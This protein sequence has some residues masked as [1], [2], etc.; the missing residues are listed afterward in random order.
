M[1]TPSYPQLH[2]KRGKEHAVSKGHPW[3]FAG[4]IHTDVPIEQYGAIFDIHVPDGNKFIARGYFNGHSQIAFRA[5]TRDQNEAID[6]R[7]FEKKFRELFELRKRFINTRST[8]AFRC[9][10]GESDGIPGLI[11]DKYNDVFVIQIHTMGMELLR[12]TIVEAMKE[13]YN[14]KTIYERSDVGVRKH[15]NLPDEP[16]GHVWGERLTGEVEILEHNVKFLVNVVDG[17][18][19]GFFLDQRDNRKALQSYCTGKRVLNCFSY[20]GGFSVYAA[21]AGATETISVDVAAAALETAK[22][23]FEINKL[24]TNKHQFIDMDVFNY[25]DQCEKKGEKFDVIILDPPAFVKNKASL[26]KG[27]AG[28]LYINERALHLLP[29][30][31]ILVS[32]SCSAHVSDEMLQQTLSMAAA[33]AHCTLKAVEIRHQPIDHPFNVQFIEGK[34]LKYYVMVKE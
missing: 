16:K 25:I 3:I 23:N 13:V 30:G 19:T 5:L 27:L 17:Q 12:K 6:Q 33:R 20:T 8:N 18:K 28:Y 14:P 22:R 9:V 34:Y 2:I 1:T 29:K 24:P 21:L 4:A 15:E 31:G 26:K 10:F 11:I 32:S 7:F